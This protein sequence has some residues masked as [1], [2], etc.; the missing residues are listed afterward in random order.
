[1]PESNGERFC[2][3]EKFHKLLFEGCGRIDG[4]YA[5]PL[6]AAAGRARPMHPSARLVPVPNSK[7]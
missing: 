6:L 1:M 5:A 7:R 3:V 2:F 4:T